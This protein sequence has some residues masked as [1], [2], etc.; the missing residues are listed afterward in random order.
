M[1]AC[2]HVYID[3]DIYGYVCMYVCMYVFMYVYM[4][5]CMHAYVLTHARTHALSPAHLQHILDAHVLVR[6]V[7]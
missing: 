7:L 6:S 4:Y 3:I 2:M 5:V 1:H